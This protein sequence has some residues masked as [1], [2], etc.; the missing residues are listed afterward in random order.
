MR[1]RELL[2]EDRTYDEVTVTSKNGCSIRSPSWP[3]PAVAV[4]TSKVFDALVAREKLGS[5]GIGEGI[6]IP[7]AGWVIA[8]PPWGCC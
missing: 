3:R 7:I 5:T 1:V 8:T 4:S 6:A 2:T